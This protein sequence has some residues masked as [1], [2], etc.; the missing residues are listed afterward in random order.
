MRLLRDSSDRPQALLACQLTHRHWTISQYSAID[1]LN[2][3]PDRTEEV[4][5]FIAFI[6]LNSARNFEI[7]VHGEAVIGL[8]PLL[9]IDYSQPSAQVTDAANR[10]WYVC[11]S[12]HRSYNI[13]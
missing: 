2:G 4:S 10:S 13:N 11:R 9:S 8:Y 7:Q 5:S 3:R 12:Q 1:M 6:Y